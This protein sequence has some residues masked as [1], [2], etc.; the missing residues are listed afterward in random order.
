[1]EDKSVFLLLLN[2]LIHDKEHINV[3][4]S[5]NDKQQESGFS[6]TISLRILSK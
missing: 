2:N 5:I 4:Q 6:G 1:M 3:V